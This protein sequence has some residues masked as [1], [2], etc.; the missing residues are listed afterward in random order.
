M[1]MGVY[2]MGVLSV[3]SIRVPWVNSLR[4]FFYD[5][6]EVSIMNKVVLVGRLGNDPVQRFT[7]TG[8][9]V[10]SFSLA[11]NYKYTNEAGEKVKITDWH[12]IKCWNGLGKTVHEYAKKGKLVC[13]T[14][15]LRTEKYTVNGEDKYWTE[16]VADEVEFLSRNP[17][18]EEETE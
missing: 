10:V 3:S 1:G 11:T 6:K 4:H 9:P 12:N 15:R 13:V 14:G 18:E 8:K 7:P 17:G 5:I 16:I 2:A